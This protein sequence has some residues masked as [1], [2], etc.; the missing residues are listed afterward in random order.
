MTANRLRRRGP[1]LRLGSYRSDKVFRFSTIRPASPRPGGKKMFGARET[2]GRLAGI[3][4]Q[5]E[6]K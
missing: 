1:I 5:E 6:L 3:A 4:G 2:I